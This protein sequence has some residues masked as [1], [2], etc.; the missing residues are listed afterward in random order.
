MN[1]KGNKFYKLGFLPKA[2]GPQKG[3]EAIRAKIVVGPDGIEKLDDWRRPVM[4]TLAEIKNV[5]ETGTPKVLRLVED[6]RIDGKIEVGP[7]DTQWTIEELR[8]IVRIVE[9]ERGI[10]AEDKEE[11]PKRGRPRKDDSGP[12]RQS[13][14]PASSGDVDSKDSKSAG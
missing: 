10:S 1:R 9:R 13:E 12:D 2:D 8:E 7:A 11:A 3:M 4:F 14:G 6:G 5:I